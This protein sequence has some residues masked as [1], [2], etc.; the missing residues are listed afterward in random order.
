MVA[1]LAGVFGLPVGDELAIGVLG[2][3]GKF[4]LAAADFF[5]GVGGGLALSGRGARASRRA[6]RVPGASCR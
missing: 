4:A 1:R 2:L 5:E 3:F 6:A